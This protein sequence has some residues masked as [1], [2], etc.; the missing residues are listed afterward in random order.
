[1]ASK[2]KP[3]PEGPRAVTPY[4]TVKGAAEALEYYKQA[5]G[6]VETVRLVGPDG[7]VG[8]AEIEING[9]PIMLSEEYP[10]ME[11]V[12]PA[13]LGGS[14]VGLHLLVENSDAVFDRAVKLGATAM[15]PVKDQF[16]GER[17]GKLKDPFGHVWYISTRI[18]EVSNEEM[19]RRA[20]AWTKGEAKET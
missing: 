13:T 15:N 11:V 1:M 9:T 18:E 14:P 12:S 3:I 7:R 6:A 8:H 17:S 16:Y 19:V 4:L 2:V 20:E 5:L 10:E